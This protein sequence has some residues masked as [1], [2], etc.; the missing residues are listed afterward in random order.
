MN[1]EI[2]KRLLKVP[3]REVGEVGMSRAKHGHERGP[4]EIASRF[5]F[6]FSVIVVALE[7]VCGGP[8]LLLRSLGASRHGRAKE[9]RHGAEAK[10]HCSQQGRLAKEG[11]MRA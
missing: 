3:G 7:I 8:S 4:N 5:G 10:S 9:G 11:G 1:Y 6:H 2:C